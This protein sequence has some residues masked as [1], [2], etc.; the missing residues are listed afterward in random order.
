MKTVFALLMLTILVNISSGLFFGTPRSTCSRD[1]DC[2]SRKCRNNSNFF[3]DIGNLFRG[4][5]RA[6]NCTYRTCAE[7]TNNNHCPGR[8]KCSGYRCVECTFNSECAFSEECSAGRCIY[9]TPRNYNTYSGSSS[10][11][12]P[13]SSNIPSANAGLVFNTYTNPNLRG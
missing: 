3:C 7:C 9:R 6:S 1:Y 4:N 2:R 12:T 13:P 10:S 5:R 11:Y 8:Q